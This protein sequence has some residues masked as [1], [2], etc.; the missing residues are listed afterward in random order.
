MTIPFRFVHTAD[1]HLDSPL[2]SL[3]RRDAALA[4]QVS[5]ASR[6]AL[7]RTIDLCLE[8]HVHALL[9]AGDIYD[10]HNPSVSSVGHFLR[11]LNRLKDSGT[12]VYLIRGNHDQHS[13]LSTVRDLPDHVVEF[14][15]NKKLDILEEFEVAIHG[16]SFKEEHAENNALRSFKAPS[17]KHRN[18]AM[19]HTSLGGSEGH[20]VYA[21][22][23]IADLDSAG[24]NYWALG[25]I[26]K[27]QVTGTESTI[28]MP[29][30]PQGRDMGETGEKSVSLV[31]MDEQ[32]NCDVQQRIVAPVRLERLSIEFERS[33]EDSKEPLKH[34]TNLFV[35]K[36]EV[37]QAESPSTNHWIVRIDCTG[38]SN[39]LYSMRTEAE[40]TRDALTLAAESLGNVYI[41]K[42]HF[43]A[44][45]S[46]Q[47]TSTQ[48][49]ALL[50]QLRSVV[51]ENL[52][53]PTLQSISDK[54][55]DDL[56]KLL[57]QKR[58]RDKLQSTS[59]I[60]A[61]TINKYQING[62]D[63]LLSLIQFDQSSEG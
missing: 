42:I 34:L 57:P 26:H 58:L 7:K 25:H 22:C 3:A 41:D 51:L 38:S 39:D 61:N 20:D 44:I 12:R 59:E 54:E 47:F 18:I 30:I 6:E 56:V 9:I 15:G 33:P 10:S 55:F 4:D 27:R 17:E 11:E 14:V 2:K 29:G 60:R 21:P 48:D 46:K 5:N 36:V 63:E 13:K 37:L 49:N 52:N 62:V 16:V 1:L 28:V 19:L 24:F 35:Q 45:E 8:E 40:H 23:S 53:D 43:S 50:T 31:T 32:G